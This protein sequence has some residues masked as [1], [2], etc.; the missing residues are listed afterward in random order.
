MKNVAIDLR[1]KN[2]MKNSKTTN[3][4]I[5]EQSKDY[6]SYLKCKYYFVVGI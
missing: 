2:L 3:C 4:I 1:K 6:V 5:N